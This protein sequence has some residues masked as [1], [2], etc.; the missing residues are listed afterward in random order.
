M[1]FSLDEAMMEIHRGDILGD[2]IWVYVDA[3][4][5]E[6]TMTGAWVITGKI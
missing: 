6:H 3:E 2:C 1:L 4:G 5:V